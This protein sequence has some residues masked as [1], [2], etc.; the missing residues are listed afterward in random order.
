MINENT[1]THT[2]IVK[3]CKV[4]NGLLLPMISCRRRSGYSDNGGEAIFS[5]VT[6]VVQ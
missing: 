3:Q 2:R 1:H 5:V 6:T 4:F